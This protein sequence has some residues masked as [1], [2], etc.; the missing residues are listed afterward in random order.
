MIYEDYGTH[1][2]SSFSFYKISPSSTPK[3]GNLRWI[4]N[5]CKP[6]SQGYEKSKTGAWLFLAPWQTSLI[7]DRIKSFLDAVSVSQCRKKMVKMCFLQSPVIK[8]AT[9]LNNH[10]SINKNFTNFLKTIAFSS[11]LNH[12]V[13]TTT[14]KIITWD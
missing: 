12:Q 14:T 5:G 2:Q 9:L 3:S 11:I 7:F 8:A 13:R 4:N 1:R 10:T 6:N